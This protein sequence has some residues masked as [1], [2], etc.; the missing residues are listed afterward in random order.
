[1]RISPLTRCVLSCL[2]A[3]S[4]TA[5][6]PVTMTPVK[7]QGLPF[8]RSYQAVTVPPV[9]QS[10]S[11]RVRSLIQAGNLYLTV[12]DALH[13]ALENNLELEV[14]R[15]SLLAA[16]WAIQRA[17][18]GGPLRGVT[19]ASNV[20]I[21]LGSGQGVAG[22]SGGSSGTGGGGSSSLA[23][24]ALIQQIGP[25][26]PQLDPVVTTN[27]SLAHQTTPLV[28]LVQAGV[29]ELVDS[30]RSYNW[31]TS[32][33]LLSGGTVRMT[34]SGSYL[35]EAAPTDVLNPTS[36]VSLGV[37]VSQRLLAGF[38]ER[39][40]GRFIRIAQRRAAGSKVT[41]ES[42]LM[43]LVTN[44]LNAYW[45]LSLATNDLKY[46]Q[47]NRDIARQFLEDTRRQIAAGAVPA[48]DRVRAQNALAAQEQA[49]TTAQNTLVQRENSMRDLLSWHGEQDP[50]LAAAHIIPVDPLQVPETDDLPP[51]RQLLE[52]ATGR[53]PDVGVARMNSEIA[54]ITTIGSASGLLPS[55]SVAASATNYGQ[56]GQAVPGQSADPYSVGGVGAALGQM[57]RRNFP[58]E[59]VSVSF[60]AGL[61]NSQAQADYAIDQLS[62]RQAQLSTQRLLN[63]LAVDISNQ[64][65]ALQQARTRYHSAVESRTLLERLLEG[66]E[67]KWL[68]GT[69][70]ISSLVQARRDLATAQSTE[71]AAAAAYIHTRIG[72]DQNLGRTLD[73]NN[74]SVDDTIAGTGK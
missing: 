56:T 45:D 60:N 3:A 74:V 64:V 33:G 17:E 57:F 63:Q 39:V 18:S 61:K 22:S 34:Y 62:Q 31:Q 10:A 69:S 50:D 14:E 73:V 47:R 19:G 26:T 9:R 65:L 68:A 67:K 55:L 25:V 23:G 66:E 29:H 72:L 13:L 1:M 20:S 21:N 7:P 46:K 35:N 53:R 40:N 38:G 24:A 43:G 5:Q 28:Q 12:H 59:R 11:N 71:L 37:S 15:Y 32:Q 58:N 6:V 27:I 42:R 51:L 30:A 49:L 41:F 16:D 8:F 4:L 70:T 36:F 2:L 44:V 48:V 54:G 52:T